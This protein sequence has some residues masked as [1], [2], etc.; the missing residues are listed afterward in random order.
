[1]GPPSVRYQATHLAAVDTPD[2]HG[3]LSTVCFAQNVTVDFM[4]LP[5]RYTR[6]AKKSKL[7]AAEEYEPDME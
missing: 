3:S 4:L 1:M 5:R 7:A 2:C 6:S